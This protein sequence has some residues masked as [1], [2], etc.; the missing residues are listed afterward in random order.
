MKPLKTVKFS[1]NSLIF[2]KNWSVKEGGVSKTYLPPSITYDPIYNF[3]NRF[4][5]PILTPSPFDESDVIT[6][7]VDSIEDGYRLH[8]GDDMIL[9]SGSFNKTPL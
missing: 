2:S 9:R 8:P 6:R 4:D 1:K 7:S 3:H 5:T